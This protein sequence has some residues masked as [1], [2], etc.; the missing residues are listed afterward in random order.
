MDIYYS[1]MLW[2]SAHY[3]RFF[4]C[5]CML[6]NQIELLKGSCA[7]T[8]T[9]LIIFFLLGCGRHRIKHNRIWITSN[10]IQ[11]HGGSTLEAFVI[12]CFFFHQKNYAICF[13]SLFKLPLFSHASKWNLQIVKYI[14]GSSI[15]IFVNIISAG[16]MI[17]CGFLLW[18]YPDYV[19]CVFC[20]NSTI[21]F[22]CSPLR[23]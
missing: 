10:S 9:F 22:N 1:I 18:I 17:S 16:I 14:F 12:C 20:F 7:A 13:F 21:H 4:V 6:S 19:C 15:I 23:L 3:R 2:N 5:V 11:S 8:I